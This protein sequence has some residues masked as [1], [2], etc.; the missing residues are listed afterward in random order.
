[1]IKF[2]FQLKKSVSKVLQEKL[3]E[4]LSPSFFCSY[5]SSFL[6]LFLDQQEYFILT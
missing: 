3:S 4:L 2:Q 1:M 5:A 6:C